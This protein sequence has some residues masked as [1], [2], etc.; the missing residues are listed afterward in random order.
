MP[1][2]AEQ[3]QVV[4]EIAAQRRLQRLED[5]VEGHAQ[6]LHFVPI[7]VE[8]DRRIRRGERAEDA[9]ELRILIGGHDEAAD[10]LR[11][12]FRIPAAQIFKDIAE[13]AS[14][15]EP[16]DRRR[17]DRNH[18]AAIYKTKFRLK[19]GDHL[20]CGKRWVFTILERLQRDNHERRI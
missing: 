13:A 3:I 15:A 7:Y 11:Q 2:S 9:V 8:I 5:A 20:S 1:S 6:N 19:P 16:K 18:G 14:G 17:R 12:A 4:H 10:S